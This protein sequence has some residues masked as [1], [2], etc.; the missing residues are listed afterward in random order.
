MQANQ[1]HCESRSVRSHIS[2]FFDYPNAHLITQDKIGALA[3]RLRCHSLKSPA[4]EHKY[5][6]D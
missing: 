1:F 2:I 6:A 3:S 5:N 4:A